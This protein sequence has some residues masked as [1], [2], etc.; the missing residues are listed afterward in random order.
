MWSRYWERERERER[1]KTIKGR[2]KLLTLGPK[3]S[4]LACQKKS[5]FFNS[6]PQQ[7][8]SVGPNIFGLEL[9]SFAG[10]SSSEWWD[11]SPPPLHYLNF[12]ARY[13]PKVAPHAPPSPPPSNRCACNNWLARSGRRCERERER[14]I[15]HEKRDAT[16]EPAQS[17]NGLEQA[18]ILNL[19]WIPTCSNNIGKRA[20]SL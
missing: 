5:L 2:Q 16:V 1:N 7:P 11:Y 8:K 20:F 18:R 15:K 9:A 6:C 13:V 19:S 10:L 4:L 14:E 3:D 17:E 12:A